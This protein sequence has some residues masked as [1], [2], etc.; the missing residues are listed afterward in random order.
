MT[1]SE[2]WL[3][4][5]WGS[6]MK[7]IR[8][9]IAD[10]K[11]PLTKLEVACE[12][13]LLAFVLTICIIATLVQDSSV[14]EARKPVVVERIHTEIKEVPVDIAKHDGLKPDNKLA[15]RN[16]NFLNIK[17]LPGGIESFSPLSR[18]RLLLNDTTPTRHP[19]I[20]CVAFTT[21]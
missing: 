20:F 10:L 9:F 17:A 11:M 14:A 21:A 5:R 16:I 6:V 2:Y 8:E 7:I 12:L 1:R 13:V 18:N 4:Y 15:D 19:R 3:K